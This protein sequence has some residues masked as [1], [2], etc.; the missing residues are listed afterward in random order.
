MKNKLKKCMIAA[1]MTAALCMVVGCGSENDNRNDAG[2][3]DENMNGSRTES[4][5]GVNNGSNTTNRT[6]NTTENKT[7]NQ[8]DRLNNGT[9]TD[10]NG[11]ID[12]NVNGATTGDGKVDENGN[13]IE[14]LGENVGEGI[15]DVGEGIGEGVK[16]ITGGGTDSNVNN[17]NTVNNTTKNAPVK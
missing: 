8:T 14:N 7:E 16:D 4:T 9:V 10:N 5:D 2:V 12:N 15:K 6:D 17:N 1:V 13:I 3:T 11:V